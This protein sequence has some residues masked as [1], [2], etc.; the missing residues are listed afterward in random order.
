MEEL[1]PAARRVDVDGEVPAR[2]GGRVTA[3]AS[4]VEPQHAVHQA[5]WEP[6]S[7]RVEPEPRRIAPRHGAPRPPDEAADRPGRV[8]RSWY[9]GRVRD[10]G[11]GAEPELVVDPAITTLQQRFQ[12][13][14]P[15]ED[16]Q[17]SVSEGAVLLSGHVSSND[18]MLRAAEIAQ[19]SS[20]EQKVIN[21]LQLPGGSGKLRAVVG[22]P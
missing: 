13:L 8:R 22:K 16:I 2:R 21:M 3:R 17:V 19:A 10:P 9:A 12:A 4:S 7:V 15:G 5:I 18:I 14:F 20:P 6:V 11:R 1:H